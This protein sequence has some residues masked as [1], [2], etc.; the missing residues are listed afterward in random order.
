MSPSKCFQ[1]YPFSSIFHFHPRNPPFLFKFRV[2]EKPPE[3]ILLQRKERLIQV[4]FSEHMLLHILL[5]NLKYTF[6]QKQKNA[7]IC[8]LINDRC[9]SHFVVWPPTLRR[10]SHRLH[11]FLEAYKIRLAPIGS[12]VVSLKNIWDQEIMK[13]TLQ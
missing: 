8:L 2:M 5:Q 6:K 13:K 1:I 9:V 10:G 7:K 11:V 3:A 4:K 12:S